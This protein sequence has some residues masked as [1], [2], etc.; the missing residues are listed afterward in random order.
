VQVSGPFE[1][2]LLLAGAKVA[3]GRASGEGVTREAAP[4]EE[5]GGSRVLDGRQSIRRKRTTAGARKCALCPLTG[6]AIARADALDLGEPERRVLDGI[7][8]VTVSS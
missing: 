6:S 8:G 1:D 4:A 7:V 3:A 2:P 5:G